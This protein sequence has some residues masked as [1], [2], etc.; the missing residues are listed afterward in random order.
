MKVHLECAER[1]EHIWHL[2]L[3]TPGVSDHVKLSEGKSQ[4]LSGNRTGCSQP[5]GVTV[6]WGE[7]EAAIPMD[8]KNRHMPRRHVGDKAGTWSRIGLTVSAAQ[9]C[10]KSWQIQVLIALR[11]R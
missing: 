11:K 3:L 1:E 5:A 8:I 6:P 4:H 7:T 10:A 2:W 9:W